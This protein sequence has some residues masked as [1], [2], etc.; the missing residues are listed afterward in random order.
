MK[1]RSTLVLLALAV[2]LS[3]LAAQCAAPATPQTVVETVVVKEEVEKVVT[4]EVEK[5]V[6]VTVEVPAPTEPAEIVVA[7]PEEPPNL[8]WAMWGSLTCR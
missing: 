2:V 7:I 3:L 1:S 5:E 6:I 8:D 4:K